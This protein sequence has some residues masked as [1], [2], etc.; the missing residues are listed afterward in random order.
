M[1]SQLGPLHFCADLHPDY[2]VR[3]NTQQRQRS[4]QGKL[5]V[6]ILRRDVKIECHV[7]PQGCFDDPSADEFNEAMC[8]ALCERLPSRTP[9]GPCRLPPYSSCQEKK[10]LEQNV[11]YSYTMNLRYTR[12]YF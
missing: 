3:V 9:S 10:I 2:M 6:S 1:F 5:N 4:Y 8:S 7:I 11:T 12:L